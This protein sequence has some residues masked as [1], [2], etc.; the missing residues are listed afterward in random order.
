[1]MAK[2]KSPAYQRY[3]NDYLSDPN[4]QAMTLEQE[5]AYNRLMDYCWKQGSIPTDP[6]KL[7][8]MCKNIDV[9]RM[10][11]IWKA[12]R[13]CFRP[14]PELSGRV[15]HPRLDREREKQ[16]EW[17][18]KSRLGGLRS[19]AARRQKSKG[20]KRV[21]HP[22]TSGEPPLNSSSSSSSSFSDKE[23]IQKKDRFTRSG[24]AEVIGSILPRSLGGVANA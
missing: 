14:H 1:M 17:S 23:N 3:P 22:S 12:I 19:A 8:S 13:H 4:V 7:L 9:V 21:N 16:A 15:V 18:Q 5:G 6:K 20:R 24:D 11:E 10:R 2:E